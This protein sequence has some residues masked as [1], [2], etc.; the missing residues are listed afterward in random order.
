MRAAIR[1]VAI[2]LA[3][4]AAGCTT[5]VD[6]VS[7]GLEDF[8][9]LRSWEWLPVSKPNVVTEDGSVRGLD[10]R[11]SALV[12]QELLE[13]GFARGGGNPDFYVSY[14][15]VLSSR[16][17]VIDVPMAPYLL[18]SHNASASFWIEGSRKETVVRQDLRLSVGVSDTRGRMIWEAT[19]LQRQQSGPPIGLEEAVATLCARLPQHDAPGDPPA[20]AAVP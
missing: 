2:L 11:V 4:L 19:L 8:S 6:V 3:C 5:T 17:V 9:S 18:S 1:L 15:L 7:D 16:K 12:E 20:E 10:A 13:R 14:H